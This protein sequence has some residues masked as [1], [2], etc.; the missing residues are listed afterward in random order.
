[1]ADI[2]SVLH[3]KDKAYFRQ[4]REQR[5]GI[6]L[7]RCSRSREPPSGLPPNPRAAAQRL[8]A[9]PYLGGGQPTYADYIVLGSFQ[10]ARCVSPFEL[11]GPDDPVAAWRARLLDCLDMARNAQRAA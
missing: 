6:P 3:E 1:M 4:T 7:K 9:Q 11:L 2:F 5:F 8:K 10:W